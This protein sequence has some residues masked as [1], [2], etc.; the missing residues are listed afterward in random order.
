MDSL[1]DDTV[2]VGLMLVDGANARSLFVITFLFCRFK[3]IPNR[4]TPGVG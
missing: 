3:L 1:V 2:V 4:L